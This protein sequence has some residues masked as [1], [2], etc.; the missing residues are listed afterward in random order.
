MIQTD[1]RKRLLFPNLGIQQG[2]GINPWRGFKG[3][4]AANYPNIFIQHK[5]KESSI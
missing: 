1:G 2:I 5:R 4:V 3:K